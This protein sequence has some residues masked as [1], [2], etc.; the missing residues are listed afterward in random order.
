MGWITPWDETNFALS[1]SAN[2]SVILVALRS[3][4]TIFAA[5]F[6]NSARVPGRGCRWSDNGSM[7]VCSMPRTP[8]TKMG[9]S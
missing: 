1:L 9:L 8:P 7:T 4:V 2:L 3:R 6:I 5:F